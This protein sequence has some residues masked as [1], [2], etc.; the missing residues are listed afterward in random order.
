MLGLIF[1]KK[2]GYRLRKIVEIFKKNVL[3]DRAWFGSICSEN[4]IIEL[5]FEIEVVFSKK[6]ILLLGSIFQ[7]KEG[8]SLEKLSISSKKICSRKSL[9][10]PICS[11]NTIIKLSFEIEIVFFKKQI[12]LLGSIFQKKESYRLRKIVEIFKK[13]VLLE[14]A[15]FG[16]ICSE[17]T[18][19]KLSFE[20]EIVFFKK[21][22]FL[23]GLIF[24]KK[25][26]YRLRK[27]VEIFKKNVLL[28]RAWFGSI[29]SE[30]TIIELNFE[31]EVVFSKKQI[32]LLGSIFQK[33]EGYSLEKL[34]IS[35]KKNFVLERAWFGSICSENT[36]IKLSFEIEIVFF[37]KETFLLGSI[38]Q[39][40]EGYRLRK[41]VEIF[42]KKCSSR[43]SL[44]WFICSENTIIELSFEIE[45]VFSKKQTFL[46]GS[47]FQKKQ[48]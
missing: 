25:E 3:L 15:W 6:K 22:T 23:L 44:V 43:K 39:K 18:I 30:N 31:I 42:K 16:S 38:L 32:L 40:K 37:K 47:N 27:I 26:G 20:I 11:E 36:I 46:L 29:C 48:G 35:S 8:Y 5:N 33:K 34:S 19:I 17:N 4:T 12:L 21:Q 28:E 24:Q 1:Q 10:G 13:N 45:V 7:K 2:E 41:I 14:R 9:F